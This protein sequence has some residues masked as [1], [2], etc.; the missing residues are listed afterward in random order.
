MMLLPAV[1]LLGLGLV[2]CEDNDTDEISG[3]DVRDELREALERT[4]DATNEL[5]DDIDDKMDAGDLANIDDDVKREWNENCRQLSEQAEDEDTSNE[6]TD[7][8]GDLKEALDAD[9]GDAV[10]RSR[11]KLREIANEMKDD[12]DGAG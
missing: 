12:L 10:E 3:D 1:L 11:D 2:A 9:D 6:L 4:R 8:C 7:V 5:A